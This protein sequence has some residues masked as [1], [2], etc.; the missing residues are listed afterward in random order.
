VRDLVLRRRYIRNDKTK[1]LE[2]K[3]RHNKPS[4]RPVWDME[5]DTCLQHAHRRCGGN[6]EPNVRAARGGKRH[7]VNVSILCNR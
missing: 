6:E 2:G 5:G 1:I 3:A 7:D 4:D